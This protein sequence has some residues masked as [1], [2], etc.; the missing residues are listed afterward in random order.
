MVNYK[1]NKKYKNK[2]VFLTVEVRMK[3]SSSTVRFTGGYASTSMSQ[4]LPSIKSPPGRSPSTRS[5]SPNKRSGK[6]P[7][8]VKRTLSFP[9]FAFEKEFERVRKKPADESRDPQ[10]DPLSV[11]AEKKKRKSEEEEIVQHEEP[12]QGGVAVVEDGGEEE[13]HMVIVEEEPAQNKK[14]GVD[15][16]SDEDVVVGDEST[17]VVNEAGK[18]S[19]ENKKRESEKKKPPMKETVQ[20]ES[21]KNSPEEEKRESEK[22]KAQEKKVQK[23]LGERKKKS[24]GKKDLKDQFQKL[25]DIAVKSLSAEEDNSEGEED[26]DSV[27]G[28]WESWM[29]GRTSKQVREERGKR[30]YLKN[31]VRKASSVLKKARQAADSH[32]RSLTGSKKRNLDPEEI[33]HFRKL[34]SLA[35][36]LKGLDKIAHKPFMDMDIG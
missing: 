24:P 15:E 1:R 35:E 19:P 31:K 28:D 9:K 13:E 17:W 22:E 18:N 20:K 27:D 14:K 34:N 5:R 2:P 33:L 32:F 36:F 6:T 21:G 25:R 8:T 16:N 26:D 23:E 4:P 7:E 11:V 3:I 30:R 10:E 29:S 12:D